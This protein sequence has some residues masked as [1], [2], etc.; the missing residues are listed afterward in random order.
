MEII[1]DVKGNSCGHEAFSFHSHHFFKIVCGD[2]TYTQDDLAGGSFFDIDN[3]IRN[4][5]IF[6]VRKKSGGEEITGFRPV[7][8]DRVEIYPAPA[9]KT[10]TVR[11]YPIDGKGNILDG[12]EML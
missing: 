11:E 2:K 10:K 5:E 12:E 3:S 7:I 6:K 1:G 8:V 4:P 9:A